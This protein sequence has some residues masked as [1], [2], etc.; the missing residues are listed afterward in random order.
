[1]SAQMREDTEAARAVIWREMLSLS[2]NEEDVD[3]AYVFECRGFRITVVTTYGPAVDPY[4]A[5]ELTD[6]VAWI[7][8]CIP[9]SRWEAPV[10]RVTLTRLV[11]AAGEGKRRRVDQV[12]AAWCVQSR[13]I[14]GNYLERAS[15]SIRDAFQRAIERRLPARRSGASGQ[16]VVFAVER[17]G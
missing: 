12:G 11:A 14:V 6:G 9:M 2:T 17:C 8:G 15:F 4:S 3:R 13:P 16:V 1:M 10:L 7:S 5:A